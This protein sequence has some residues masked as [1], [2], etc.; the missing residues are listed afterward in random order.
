[1][2][3]PIRP[4]YCEFVITPLLHYTY[5]A[6]ILILGDAGTDIKPNNQQGKASTYGNPVTGSVPAVDTRNDNAPSSPS[7]SNN[8]GSP[9]DETNSSYGNYGNPSG[10]STETHHSFTNDCQPK[11]GC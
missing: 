8:N 1:M 11:K 6:H 5:R 2:Q 3:T 7:T 4:E 10:S 9:D